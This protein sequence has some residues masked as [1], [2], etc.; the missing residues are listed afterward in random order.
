VAEEG[1]VTIQGPVQEQ[2][3]SPLQKR[4]CEKGNGQG[5]TNPKGYNGGLDIKRDHGRHGKVT[6]SRITYRHM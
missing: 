6:T 5:R 4:R 2:I 1:Q 3:M